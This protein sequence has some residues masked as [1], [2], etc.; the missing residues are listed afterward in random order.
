M[1]CSSR[2]KN[3]SSI[4]LDE[5]VRSSVTPV[6]LNVALQADVV[7]TGIPFAAMEALVSR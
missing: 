4:V 6:A 5:D 2:P 7:I 3:A 1:V